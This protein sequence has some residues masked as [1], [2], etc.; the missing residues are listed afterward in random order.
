MRHDFSVHLF[1]ETA[2]KAHAE[3]LRNADGP[4]VHRTDIGNDRFRIQCTER[5][6]EARLR[7]FEGISVSPELPDQNPADTKEIPAVNRLRQQADLS[8]RAS[9][10]FFHGEPVAVSEGPIALF[11]AGDPDA[12]FGIRERPLPGRHNQRILK[13]CTE[14]REIVFIHFPEEQ[15]LRFESVRF[16]C[17]SSLLRKSGA[18]FSV[19]CHIFRENQLSGPE[20]PFRKARYPKF[21]C[22]FP[23]KNRESRVIC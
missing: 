6:A 13:H 15:T 11:I 23:L 8:D 17:R 12:D 9:G 3:T 10:G 20:K 5:I 18:V 16:H 19:I 22:G 21:N 2:R 7:P 14:C 4:E 1:V